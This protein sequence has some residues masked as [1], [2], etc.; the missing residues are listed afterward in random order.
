MRVRDVR[1]HLETNRTIAE[2]SDG[3]WAGWA[4]RLPGSASRG[5]HRTD[6]RSRSST[7]F[8]VCCARRAARQAGRPPYPKT[9][10]WASLR[11][12]A[13]AAVFALAFSAHAQDFEKANQL[14][15][16]GKFVQAQHAYEQ[17]V[18]GGTWSANLF[19]NLGNASS[20][21]GAQ[22]RAMLHYERAL[23]LDPSHADAQRNLRL[24][25]GQTGAKLIDSPLIERACRKVRESVWA[26]LAAVAAWGCVFSVAFLWMS[27]RREK[28]WLLAVASVAVAAVAG[29]GVFAHWQDRALGIVTAKEAEA[30]LAPVESAGLAD[31]LAAG[32]RVRVLSERGAWIYC[33]LPNQRRGWL[34][35][36]AVERVRVP[37]T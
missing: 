34:V 22:G 21:A 17:I 15:D 35:A 5:A 30:R 9:H 8:A 20:R 32:S 14:Y 4:S 19:Y 27:E 11:W 3:S 18:E 23:V 24:L 6:S 25:R 7:T 31:V 16:E 29:F 33:E 2:A 36:I 26:V 12:L 10:R 28:L 1:A 37:K 13:L